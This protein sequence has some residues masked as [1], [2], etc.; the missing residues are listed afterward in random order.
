MKASLGDGQSAKH[1]PVDL[2]CELKVDPRH[3]KV[4]GPQSYFVIRHVMPP[5]N[6]VD[7]TM[8]SNIDTGN[9]T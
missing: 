4:L 2:D 9:F 7:L 6:R 8:L 5:S 3:Q 1:C